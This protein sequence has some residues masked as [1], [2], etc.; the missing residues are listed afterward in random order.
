MSEY[1][2]VQEGKNIQ[3]TSWR[4][5]IIEKTNTYLI[6]ARSRE[7]ICGTHRND[8]RSY[9]SFDS[10][11]NYHLYLCGRSTAKIHSNFNKVK[12]FLCHTLCNH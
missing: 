9:I 3:R 6:L 7:L 2:H 8:G 12:L 11:R 4:N 10:M 5:T 1:I